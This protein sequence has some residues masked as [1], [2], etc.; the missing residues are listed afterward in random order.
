[1]EVLA[2]RGLPHELEH[3]SV[4]VHLLQLFELILGELVPE[5]VLM[6]L[7]DSLV[8]SRGH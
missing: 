1:M 2:L 3:L 7:S 6:P 5:H 4:E 8:I